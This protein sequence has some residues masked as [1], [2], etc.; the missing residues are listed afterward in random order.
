MD[1]GEL[2]ALMARLADGDRSAFSSVFKQLWGPVLRFCTSMLKSEADAADA[3]QQAMQKILERASDYDR[4]RRA[5]PWAFAIAAWEC[6]TLQRRH[7]R[8]KEVPPEA[9]PEPAGAHGED[10]FVQRDLAQAALSA[11]GELSDMDRDALVATFWDEAP[12]VGGSTL[13]KRRERA[14]D[15]LR[16]TFRRLYGLD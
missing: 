13:R 16:G 3:A 10:E 11:L 4:R 12:A 7:F 6:K 2:D 8:R 14:L 15:R 5:M 9:S 1:G